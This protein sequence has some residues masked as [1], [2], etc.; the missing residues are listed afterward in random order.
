MRMFGEWEV[1]KAVWMQWP[2]SYEKSYIPTFREIVK[3]VT[4]LQDCVLVVQKQGDKAKVKQLLV[5]SGANVERVSFVVCKYDNAWMRDN[6]P[7]WGCE[8]GTPILMDFEFDAWGKSKDALGWKNDN[9]VTVKIAPEVVPGAQV[10]SFNMVLE[11]GNVESNG[12]DSVVLCWPTQA[13]RNP[14]IG[15]TQQEEI[16]K[17]AFG[18]QTKIVWLEQAPP[19][20]VIT[21]GH[22]DGMARF[23][24]DKVIVVAQ[25]DS[26]NEDFQAYESAAETLS[27]AG[28]VVIRLQTGGDIKY[29]REWMTANYLNWVVGNGFVLVPAFGIE[30]DQVAKQQIQGFFPG[31]VVELVDCRELW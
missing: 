24:S 4:R 6:G 12:I 15:R 26:Q 23:I 13:K 2:W 18:T 17:N 19:S 31:R 11:G 25:T 30:H 16:L 3:H 20:D 7:I 14:S 5:E 28:F 10:R 21:G 8:N 29:K 27:K 1:Q 9:K 22:I